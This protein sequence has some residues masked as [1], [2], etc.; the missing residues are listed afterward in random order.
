MPLIPD[1]RYK[2]MTS[3]FGDKPD[4]RQL[5]DDSKSATTEDYITSITDPPRRFRH[6]LTDNAPVHHQ[7]NP[8]KG[9]LEKEMDKHNAYKVT[10]D[11]IVNFDKYF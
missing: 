3:V 7:V 11:D 8:Y 1:L 4:Q 2:N 6:A 9:N 10:L 5:A